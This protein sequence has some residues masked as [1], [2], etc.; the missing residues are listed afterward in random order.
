MTQPE[1]RPVKKRTRA[2]LLG[3]RTFWSMMSRL[4]LKEA[5]QEGTKLRRKNPSK[6]RI[7]PASK[8]LPK[9]SLRRNK[10]SC[11]NRPDLW[12]KTRQM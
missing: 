9:K 4:R 5:K 8:S 6:T 11:L 12:V 3:F 7:L 1:A 2:S 10:S